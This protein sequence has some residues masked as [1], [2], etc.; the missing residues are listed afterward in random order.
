M[1]GHFV[2]K[3]MQHGNLMTWEEPKTHKPKPAKCVSCQRVFGYYEL[4]DT[5]VCAECL[6][7]QR[8]GMTTKQRQ[9]GTLF[10]WKH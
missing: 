9:H 10:T 3:K 2:A 5:D 8:T 1:S 4:S 7:T 6:E